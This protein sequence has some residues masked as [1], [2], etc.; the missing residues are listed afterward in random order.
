MG[1]LSKFS[2]ILLLLVT[3]QYGVNGD[4]PANCT[5]D[6]LVGNWKFYLS[7]G[8]HSKDVD[9]SNPGNNFVFVITY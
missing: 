7:S 1:F 5:H 9:C 2:S 6:D 3:F 4:T 8:G